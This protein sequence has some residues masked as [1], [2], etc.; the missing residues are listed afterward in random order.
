MKSKHISLL[1][2]AVFGLFVLYKC[3]PKTEPKPTSSIFNNK[4]ATGVGDLYNIKGNNGFD[5]KDVSRGFGKIKIPTLFPNELE[6]LYGRCDVISEG[7]YV[8]SVVA[9]TRNPNQAQANFIIYFDKKPTLE[10][11]YSLVFDKKN[12][13]DTSVHVLFTDIAKTQK[14]WVAVKGKVSF[15]LSGSRQ[16]MLDKLTGENVANPTDTIQFSGSVNCE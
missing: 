15:T 14:T 4:T 5:Y 13:N 12:I 10:K 2:L 1:F 16:A 7:Y 3:N 6:A 11:N 9:G 8:M